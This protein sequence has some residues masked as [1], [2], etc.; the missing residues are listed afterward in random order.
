MR[1]GPLWM[2]TPLLLLLAC[3]KNDPEASPPSGQI[4]PAEFLW[5]SATAGFQVDMG[6]PTWPASECDDTASDWYDWV[7]DPGILANANLHVRGD[8]VSM[9]PGMW[10]LLEEDADRMK[11]DGHNAY[12]MS[13]EWSRLFPERVP[14]SIASVDELTDLANPAAVQRYHEIFGALR[15]RGIT[16]AVT[17]NHYVLPR[18]IHDGVA[19]HSD[20]ESCTDRGWLDRDRMVHHIGLF[21]GFLNC[22]FLFSDFI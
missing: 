15:D 9:G 2:S 4:F 18:W 21:A 1:S 20:V 14:D 19:C 11:A 8:P 17:V 6:C 10:E 7:T 16:P 13:V 12:R 5:G 22:L 3:G